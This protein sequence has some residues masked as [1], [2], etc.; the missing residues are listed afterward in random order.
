MS[1]RVSTPG[2]AGRMAKLLLAP[3]I[4][5]VTLVA[6]V[7]VVSQRFA[8]D[9]G[10]TAAPG[11]SGQRNAGR[12]PGGSGAPAW[13]PGVKVTT[14][15]QQTLD[16]LPEGP[17]YV[18]RAT[19]LEMEPG[20][21]IFEHRQLSAGAHV[22][23]RGAIAI[24]NLDAGQTALYRAGQAFFEGPGP[25]HRAENPSQEA[26]RILMFDVLSAS[27]GFDGTQQFTS[28]GRHNE[29]GL[30]SG[31]YVQ[32]PLPDLP[33]EP[34]MVRVSEMAFGPKEKTV[35]HTRLGPAMFFVQEGTATVR[36]D[37]DN[38]SMTYGTNGYFYESG[39]EAFILENKPVT[40]AR[41]LAVELLPADLGDAPSTVPTGKNS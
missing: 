4:A 16:R 36:K 11:L 8:A 26:N 19:E 3:A 28:G 38:S 6:L 5:L 20:A 32:V 10:G 21:R 22:V 39:R 30:R 23:I 34:L 33:A 14:V 9:S 27:R 25:L 24:E 17:P 15:F 1:Q 18:M 12:G 37:W 2:H 13:G 31:P 35:E 40:P 7:S 29:G 41:F